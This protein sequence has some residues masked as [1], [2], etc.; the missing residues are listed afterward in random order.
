MGKTW[1]G[2][3]RKK[4][5]KQKTKRHRSRAKWSSKNGGRGTAPRL[6]TLI[7]DVAEFH[8]SGGEVKVPEVLQRKSEPPMPMPK[9][10]VQMKVQMKLRKNT[11]PLYKELNGIGHERKAL[12]DALTAGTQVGSTVAVGDVTVS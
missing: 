4:F 10:K 2:A 9:R 1:S 3:D 6:R 5:G 8:M 12:Y 11:P 7:T